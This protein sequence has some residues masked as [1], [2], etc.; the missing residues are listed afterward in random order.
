MRLSGAGT[1][2]ATG[3]AVWAAL[4][5]R[6]RLLRALPGISQLD[7]PGNGRCE[8]TMTTAMAPVSGTYTGEA[9]IRYAVAPSALGLHVSAAGA[10]GTISADISVRLTPGGD[11]ATEVSYEADAEVA[12]PLAGIGQRMLTSIARRLAGDVIGGL[13]KVLT[14]PPAAPPPAGDESVVERTP[15]GIGRPGRRAGQRPGLRMRQPLP[16]FDEPGSAARTAMVAG[17]AAGLAGLAGILLGV[18]F[19]RRIRA[20]SRDSRASRLGGR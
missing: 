11:D 8:F 19:G 18:L 5:D 7:V 1:V 10:R 9:V 3:E 15:Q 4:A 14:A 6:N 2:H 16:A 20:T 13:D 17:A 12:V